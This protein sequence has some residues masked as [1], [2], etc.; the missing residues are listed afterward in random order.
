L[1]FFN[2]LVSDFTENVFVFISISFYFFTIGPTGPSHTMF[3]FGFIFVSFCLLAVTFPCRVPFGHVVRFVAPPMGPRMVASFVVAVVAIFV[4]Q[5]DIRVH[6]RGFA[7]ARSIGI[8]DFLEFG[9]VGVTVLREQQGFVAEETDGI[10][11]G[12]PHHLA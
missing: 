7:I 10:G 1:Y 4:V 8:D 3:V 2:G 5:G 12:P 9:I 11:V 6:R